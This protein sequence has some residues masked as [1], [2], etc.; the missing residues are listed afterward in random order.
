LA[1][2]RSGD[3]IL[4]PTDV[5]H[6]EVAPPESDMMAIPIAELVVALWQ[7]RYWWAKVTV[8]GLLVSVGLFFLS[9][10]IPDS[11]TSTARLMPPDQQ[12]FAS[13]SALNPVSEMGFS[14]IER[15]FMSDS[16]PAEVTM[17]VLRS[18]TVQDDVID[19]LD[20][21]RIH[22]FK[23]R[24]AA[25]QYLAGMSGFTQEK[26][27]GMIIISVEAPDK[28][29]ARNIAQ[30]Y[31]DELNKL[32]SDLSSSSARRERIFLEERLKSVKA[33]L[34]TSS[35]ALSEFSSKN[36]TFDPVRQGQ[37]AVEAA[38]KLQGD[39]ITAES[40]VSGLKAE[41][42][43]DNVR[44]RQAQARVDQLQAQLQKMGGRSGASG[45]V[46]G[47]SGELLPPVRELPL[48]GYTYADLFRQVQIDESLYETLT[49][50]YEMAK[51]DEAKQIPMIKVLDPPDIPEIK[52]FPRRRLIVFI[53]GILFF[54][55]AFIWIIVS[56]LWELTS[57]SSSL[58]QNW[59]AIRGA[60][61]SK[62]GTAVLH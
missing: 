16:S 31:I 14:S 54:V 49:K 38:V 39:L 6:E 15:S 29:L 12:A 44:V 62:P 34:D 43:D 28:V 32:V 60:I 48:L 57:E 52:S 9:Y 46:S 33:D 59:S 24:T 41:Y 50:Q 56:K 27:T 4:I 17:G 2:C 30:A 61:R 3:E 8:I 22:Q 42:T 20:L 21:M 40:Q 19:H 23:T 18:R 51:V 10:L 36:A 5:Q 13:V 25:R 47:E 11:Y 1:F 45:G 26:K 7:R 37:S 55:G 35:R 58:K 53:G